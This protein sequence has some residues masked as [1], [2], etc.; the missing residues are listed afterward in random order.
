M[1]IACTGLTTKHFSGLVGLKSHTLG[2]YFQWRWDKRC[3]SYD[4]QVLVRA[5]AWVPGYGS[6]MVRVLGTQ[7]RNQGFDIKKQLATMLCEEVS[8]RC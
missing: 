3:V 7:A 4:V 8:Y 6:S 1:V 2:W 5:G